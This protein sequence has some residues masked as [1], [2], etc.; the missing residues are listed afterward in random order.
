MVLDYCDLSLSTIFF[1]NSNYQ[2]KL[3]N[4]FLLPVEPQYSF[5]KI[6]PKVKNTTKNVPVS[7]SSSFSNLLREIE[8]EEQNVSSVSE[9][10]ITNE[11]LVESEINDDDDAEDYS[12]LIIAVRGRHPLWDHR[13][14]MSNRYESIKQ[15]LWDEIYVELNG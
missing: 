14:P 4:L 3:N 13:I 9:F 10:N 11:N 2:L 1:Y 5:Q 12:K 8:I 7:A 15:K 6:L